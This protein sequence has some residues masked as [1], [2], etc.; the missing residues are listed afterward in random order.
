MASV[1]KYSVGYKMPFVKSELQS[2]GLSKKSGI[3]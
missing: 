1:N 2:V 3:I